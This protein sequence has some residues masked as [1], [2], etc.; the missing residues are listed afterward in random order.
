MHSVPDPE[1]KGD[2]TFLVVW[3]TKVKSATD[4]IYSVLLEKAR[5]SAINAAETRQS[6]YFV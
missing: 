4:I 3:M 5:Q 2:C 6:A 1:D